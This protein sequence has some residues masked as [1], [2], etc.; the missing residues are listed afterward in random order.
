MISKKTFHKITNHL[1]TKTPWQF[2]YTVYKTL[3]ENMYNHQDI[4]YSEIHDLAYKDITDGYCC[5]FSS[6]ASLYN[7]LIG[8][9][10]RKESYLLS[11]LHTTVTNSILAILSLIEKGLDYQ[12]DILI[13]HCLYQ[14]LLLIGISIDIKKFDKIF[15]MRREENY[16]DYMNEFS[17]KELLGTIDEYM[18]IQHIP[19][20]KQK[21]LSF[22]NDIN[23]EDPFSFMTLSY[24]KSQSFAGIKYL[25][26]FGNYLTRREFYYQRLCSILYKTTELYILVSQNSHITYIHKDTNNED[27]VYAWNIIMNLGQTINS[28]YKYESREISENKKVS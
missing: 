3:L 13:D 27:T 18:H 12:L 7:T 22:H 17:I 14:C 26:I 20:S 23:P 28:Y 10:Y 15:K 2:D 6:L 19:L 25:N 4:F 21:E 16:Q 5:Y 8:E 1:K 11:T 24:T 9:K